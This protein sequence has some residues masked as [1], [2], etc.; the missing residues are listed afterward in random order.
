VRTR[1][2]SIFG[3]GGVIWIEDR[4]VRSVMHNTPVFYLYYIIWSQWHPTVGFNSPFMARRCGGFG[5][6]VCLSRE[7][8]TFFH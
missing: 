3:V 4:L 6:L 7:G 8:D 5:L 1:F 2:A